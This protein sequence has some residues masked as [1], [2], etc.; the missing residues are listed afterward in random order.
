MQIA[1]DGPAGAGKSTIAKALAK[2]LNIIYLD[3][4]AMYRGLGYFMIQ[5]NID[6]NDMINVEKFLPK[7]KLDITFDNNE[8]QIIVNGKNVTSKIREHNISKAASDV[9]KHKAVRLALVKMQQDFAKSN[10]VVLDG[11]DIGT[12]VL[13]NAEYKFYVD[14]KPEV[15]AQR[16]HL[17]LLEKGQNIPVKDIL[18]D[19]IIRDKNDSTREFAPL[20]QAEDAIYIDTSNISEKEVIDLVKSYIK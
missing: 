6:P 12:Y 19:I 17:Q 15:R 8:Q 5:N 14:A 3:T 2:E 16:R 9:S 13:P 10:N 18:A 11:R 1:I 7:F 4:G 20:K